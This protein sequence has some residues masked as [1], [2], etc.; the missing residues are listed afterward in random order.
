MPVRKLL[1]ANRGEIAV[2]IVRAARKLGCRTVQAHSRADADMLAVRPTI[3]TAV[4]RVLEVI[5]TRVL[6]QVAREKP[7]RQR[8]F[9][10]AMTIGLKRLD[11]GRLTLIEQALDPILDR[12]VRAKVRARFGGRLIGRQHHR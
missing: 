1:V 4:P 3:L 9:R 5:R 10:M 11:G 6:T 12:L 7:F 8:L 2:R